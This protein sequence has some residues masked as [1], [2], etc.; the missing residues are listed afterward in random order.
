MS[1]ILII[2][3]EATIRR[4]LTKEGVIF[5]IN[6]VVSLISVHF[7]ANP[8]FDFAKKNKKKYDIV[9]Y[10]TDG[11]GRFNY[12]E[13]PEFKKNTLWLINCGGTKA[14]AKSGVVYVENSF[15]N[16]GKIIPIG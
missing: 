16:Y 10:L 2:E 4:V 7:D 3:D 13:Y 12:L 14:Q 9:V 6:R 8:V 15:P 11:F 5:T 1:R